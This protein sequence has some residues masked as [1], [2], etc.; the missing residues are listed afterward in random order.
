V[1][2]RANAEFM[3]H[4]QERNSNEFYYKIRR[5]RCYSKFKIWSTQANQ[6]DM[7]HPH[8]KIIFMIEYL[9]LIQRKYTSNFKNLSREVL[10][11]GDNFY[12][13]TFL[14]E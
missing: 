11:H 3:K 4:K 1:F 8:L 2:I 10:F 13:S 9:K 12:K 5:K 6:F 14:T 7:L